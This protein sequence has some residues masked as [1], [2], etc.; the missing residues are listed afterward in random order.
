ML[1]WFTGV[2]VLFLGATL[3]NAHTVPQLE[4]YEHGTYRSTP[5]VDVGKTRAG[6]THGRIAEI[7]LIE[8]TDT[9]VA[10]LGGEFGFRFRIAGG[11]QGEVVP[12]KIVTKFPSEGLLPP[13]GNAPVAIDDYDD[14][15][16]V[17]A[18]AF[19][20]WGFDSRDQLVPGLWTIEV[21]Q[22]D[23]KLG[24]HSFHVILP[25]IS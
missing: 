2:V 20:T 18:N 23:R 4:I 19:L 3:A 17:G 24:G 22:G 10:Q 6:F 7:E 11:P 1:K 8:S 14:F 15:G 9:V 5:T 13:S 12:L 25:P 21:W 16:I